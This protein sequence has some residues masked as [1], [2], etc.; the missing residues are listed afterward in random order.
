MKTKII[1]LALITA[2]ILL[3]ATATMII[4]ANDNAK[5]HAKAPEKSPVIGDNWDIERVDF[6]HY[7]KPAKPGGGSS[8]GSCYKLMG[9]KWSTLPVNYQI[10]PSNPQGLSETFVTTAIST[11]AETWDAA[12]GRELFNNA[13]AVNYSLHYGVYDGKNAIE[14]GDYGNSNVI[15]ITSVWFSRKTKQIT[16][17]DMLFNTN[18]NWG[19]GTANASLMDL[20]DIA[21]H[22]LG[23]AVGLNDLYSGSCSEMTMYGYSTEGETKKT[24]L[25][26]PDITG[27]QTMYGA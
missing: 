11:S 10:N 3:T 16:E 12:T 1:F 13:Y 8:G 19:N 24:T 18:F 5:D 14:F 15:A 17:F 2:S 26:Q 4:P 20:Q 21:T 6:I 25:E 7:V 23:H 27:L 22:E 9:V